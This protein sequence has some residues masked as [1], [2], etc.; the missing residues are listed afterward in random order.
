MMF[1]CHQFLDTSLFKT[2][3]VNC[4]ESFEISRAPAHPTKSDEDD[5]DSALQILR[6]FLSS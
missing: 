3:L 1:K 6:N 5:T 4:N 2:L